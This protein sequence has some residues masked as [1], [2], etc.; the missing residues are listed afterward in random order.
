MRPEDPT[1]LRASDTDRQRTA[2]RLRQAAGEGRLLVE[3]L[4]H[5][6][7]AAFSARTYE[8]LDLLVSDLPPRSD[9]DRRHLINLV[10]V[11]PAL[12]FA[13]ALLIA[14]VPMAG[15]LGL[16]IGRSSAAAPGQPRPP[17]I[18]RP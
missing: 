6:L 7:E 14:I 8:E 18:S 15:V 12:A 16:G 4:E 9:R 5:R 2:H 3:E 10:P 17:A 13:A 1:F 11:R